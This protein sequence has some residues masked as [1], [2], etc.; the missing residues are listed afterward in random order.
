MRLQ[1]SSG[2][3]ALRLLRV[4]VHNPE[5]S[6]K[7]LFAPL[8]SRGLAFGLWGVL[9]LRFST[10]TCTFN[11]LSGGAEKAQHWCHYSVRKHLS[12]T[13]RLD[14][15]TKAQNCTDTQTCTDR[16]FPSLSQQNACMC[17]FLQRGS[18]GE[19]LA[20]V[21]GLKVGWKRQGKRV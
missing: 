18:W 16:L 20:A 10:P 9:H 3:C 6:L 15:T 11:W 14:T 1:V 19:H 12:L 21:A 17:D 13:S 2:V 8:Q 5:A 7:G 4:W